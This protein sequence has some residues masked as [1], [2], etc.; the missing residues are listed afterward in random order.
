MVTH[1]KIVS[2]GLAAR[3]SGETEIASGWDVLVGPKDSAGVKSFL[4][5]NFYQER[6]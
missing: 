5:K 2:P 1:R 4:D 3:I 6:T